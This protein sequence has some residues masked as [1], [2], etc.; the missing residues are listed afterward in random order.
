MDDPQDLRRLWVM[1]R[2]CFASR[3]TA[4]SKPY[5]KAYAGLRVNCK[6]FE[7]RGA[8]RRPEQKMNSTF[9]FFTSLM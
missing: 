7:L 2:I 5:P 1:P 9:V 3:P 6:C 8:K 4:C